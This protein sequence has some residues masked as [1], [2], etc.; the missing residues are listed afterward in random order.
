MGIYQA[1][2]GGTDGRALFSGATGRALYSPL[3]PTQQALYFQRDTG[4]VTNPTAPTIIYGLSWV[5]DEEPGRT[6]LLRGNQARQV[7]GVTTFDIPPGES[8]NIDWTRVE[9]ITQVVRTYNY[10]S[11]Y[12]DTL[13]LTKSIGENTPPAAYG[14]RDDWT[15]VQDI[16]KAIAPEVK[17]T[18][19]W[20]INGVKPT[21][22]SY[23]LA[24]LSELA[25]GW[26]SYGGN[27]RYPVKAVY[28]DT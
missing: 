1:L 19:E 8:D 16:P 3:V 22:V 4:I 9:K 6:P 21:C 18:L 24:Y 7:V 17:Y 15:L 27:I 2:Y 28:Y 26:S 25:W 11:R 12:G 5:T 10:Y 13:R 23:A 20:V 14:I